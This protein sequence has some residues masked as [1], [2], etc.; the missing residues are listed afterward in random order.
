MKTAVSNLCLTMK[1]GEVFGLL[2]QNGAG[3]TTTINVLTGLHQLDG[4][5]ATVDGLDVATQ[6]SQ[7]HRV[8]GVCPQ[9]DK[10]WGDLT[11]RQHLE[12]YAQLKGV[13]QQRVA[14]A[15]REAAAKVRLDGDAFGKFA[16]QLSGGMRR[17]LS[18]AIA[19]IGSPTIIFFDEPTTG[20]DPDTRRQLWDIIKSEQSDGR[21]IVV[22]T[23]SM[24]EAD[25]LCSRIGIMGFGKLRCLGTQLHLKRKFG[26]GFKLTVSVD[27]LNR[28][29]SSLPGAICQGAQLVH[30][31]GLQRTYVL[32]VAGLDVAGLFNTLERQ[33][34]QYGVRAWGISQASLEEVF[35]KIAESSE[36]DQLRR[37]QPN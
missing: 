6:Q 37:T 2:G 33:K 23:H 5:E 15:A 19:L 27:H 25:A 36:S 12:F 11:V 9:F 7:I 13:V 3:K 1:R 32:P 21:C 18:I 35:I 14:L 26:D 29:I 22:T 10:V 20:L 24:E 34:K 31:L 28:D 17:R 16:S 4:G 8:I 30:T